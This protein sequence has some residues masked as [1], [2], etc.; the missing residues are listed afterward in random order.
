[1]AEGSRGQ[2]RWSQVLPSGGAG[3]KGELLTDVR[4]LGVKG[5]V[6]KAVNKGCCLPLVLLST[7]VDRRVFDA[8]RLRPFIRMTLLGGMSLDRTR[9]GRLVNV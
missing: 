4:T 9:Y 2:S 1:M 6:G 8:L 3:L 5:G 7:D